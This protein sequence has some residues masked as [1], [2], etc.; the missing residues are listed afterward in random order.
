MTTETPPEGSW[1]PL[2]GG[3]VYVP[4]GGALD[5]VR[6]ATERATAAVAEQTAAMRAARA[7]GH[8]LRE[9]GAAAS[10]TPGGVDYRIKHAG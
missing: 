2:L 3:T 8:S 7:V 9:I 6:A 4:P 5:M 10:M 1:V